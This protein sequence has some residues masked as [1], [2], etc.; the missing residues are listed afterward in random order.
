MKLISKIIT[1]LIV[2]CQ[3]FVLIPIT[4]AKY[5]SGKKQMIMV[6][7]YYS[8]LPNQR[9]Y[10]RGSYAGDIRLNGRGTNGA[11]GTEVYTGLLAAPRTYPF[12][13]RIKIP[14]LGVGEV[15]DRGG[16]IIARKNYDR[17]D[18]WMGYGEVGL[19]RALNWGMRLVEGEVYY[20]SHQVQSGLSFSHISSTL[21]E[22]VIQRLMRRRVTDV[23]QLQDPK[24]FN[25]P[26]T[27][28]SSKIK[29]EEL[30]EALISLGYYYGPITSKYD[31]K[32]TEAVLLFQLAEDVIPYKN[33]TGA[34]YFGPRTRATL[35][36][37]LESYNTDIAKELNRLKEN[38]GLL[39]PGLGKNTRGQIVTVLQRMLWELGYYEGRLTGRYDR[40]TIDAVFAFQKDHQI[41]TSEWDSGAGY[42]GKKTHKALIAALDIKVKEIEK[43]PMQ[44]QSWVPAKLNIPKIDNLTSRAKIERKPL[45]FS[46]K[47]IE[48]K[49]VVK[50]QLKFTHDLEL[51]DRGED[52]ARLQNILI[53]QG[54]LS[55]GLNTGYFGKQTEAALIKFQIKKGIVISKKASGAGR[56]GPKTRKILNTL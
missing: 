37:K 46:L 35:K 12:G 47:L 8:P 36:K 34:G 52:V 54:F 32:T 45:H 19:S 16:A 23:G 15:H 9:F 40:R 38:Q 31:Q 44:M 49:V 3:V 26:I 20:K 21:P 11:D 29:I 2:F 7:A 18:V 14:G 25:K 33:A 42:Y 56:V 28:A 4:H 24:V 30:Q 1:G 10:M 39:V 6:S 41:L 51:K 55:A 27:K 13:T 17:I 43:Y 5:T 53:K 50:T 22:S 48:R